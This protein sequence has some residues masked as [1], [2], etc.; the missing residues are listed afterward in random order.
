MAVQPA[1]RHDRQ[2][3][4][5]AGRGDSSSLIRGVNRWRTDWWSELR[6]PLAVSQ[7]APGRLR[8]LPLRHYGRGARSSLEGVWSSASCC[9]CSQAQPEAEKY[10]DGAPKGEGARKRMFAVTRT[11]RGARRTGRG[12]GCA[13]PKCRC[14]FY[15]L[16]RSALRLPLFF[17]RQ[18]LSCSGLA[19]LGRRKTRRENRRTRHCERS[20]AI[21]GPGAPAPGL[22]RRG[23]CHRAG[24]FGPDP[25]A[26]RNDGHSYPPPRAGAPHKIRWRILWGPHRGGGGPSREARLWKGSSVAA[27]FSSPEFRRG[28]GT[29]STIL[30]SLSLATDG[31]PPPRC[32][33]A[34]GRMKRHAG[35]DVSL[36]LRLDGPPSRQ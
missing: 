1:T 5:D 21:Q 19:K 9:K 27:W 15:R 8:T 25:L 18:T 32:Y 30:R 7:T 17:W 3:F 20:E 12:L 26:P 36:S 6:C 28:R 29:P 31:P 14:G 24:H 23:A 2:Y 22:L 16:R 34:Q 13:H 35:L 33:A 11:I 4:Q 10:R